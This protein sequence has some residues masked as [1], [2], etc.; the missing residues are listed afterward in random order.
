MWNHVNMK[1]SQNYQV[2]STF[3]PYASH[4]PDTEEHCNKPP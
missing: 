2:Q 1:L 4:T 3:F